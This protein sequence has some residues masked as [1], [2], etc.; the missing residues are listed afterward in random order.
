MITLQPDA[1]AFVTHSRRLRKPGLLAR[2]TGSGDKDTE[3]LTAMVI[4][5]RDLLVAHPRRAARDDGA[6]DAAGGRRARLAH[7]RARG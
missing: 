1:H 2:M 6:V 7:A 4:G 3:H 5:T